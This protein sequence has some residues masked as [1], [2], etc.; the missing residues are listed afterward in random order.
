[1]FVSPPTI[2]IFA[3]DIPSP[4]FSATP[5][6]FPPQPRI[7]TYRRPPNK[8]LSLFSFLFCPFCPP[9]S[10]IIHPSAPTTSSAFHSLLVHFPCSFHSIPVPIHSPSHS[11]SSITNL[12]MNTARLLITIFSRTPSPHSHII[13]LPLQS[14]ARSHSNYR[15]CICVFAAFLNTSLPPLRPDIWS[16]TPPQ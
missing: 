10:K 5:D 9:L 7:T 15:A 16:P 12:L 1:M 6:L 2:H 13:L 4:N 14:S 3:K 11:L 8:L